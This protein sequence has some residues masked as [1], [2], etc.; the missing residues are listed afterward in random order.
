[1]D[2][3]IILGKAAYNKNQIAPKIG[4]GADG[5]EIQLLNEMLVLNGKDRCWKSMSE[6][7]DCY[8]EELTKHIHAIHAPLLKG[9]GDMTLEN[10]MDI[11]DCSVLS[12][13]AHVANEIGKKF[14]RVITLIVHSEQLVTTMKDV[15]GIY[16][17]IVRSL[18][19]LLNNYGY[20]RVGIE[21][22]SPIR[23]LSVDNL[24]LSNNFDYNNVVLANMLRNELK[25]N[26]VGTILDT[27]HAMI[28]EKY[29]QGI[30]K[31]IDD[32]D[33]LVPELSMAR[34]FLENG[35]TIFHIHLCDM[36]GCGYGK[37]RHGIPFTEA[38]KDKLFS[39]LDLYTKYRY[40][41][42]LCLEVEEL[43]GFDECTG[44]RSTKALVDE[45]FRLWDEL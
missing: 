29:I 10:M 18:D 27:C 20:V 7:Y 21:N 32:S 14:N 22:V 1:M 39:I 19:S 33:Y 8:N 31:I 41:C 13:M 26:R 43:D 25:T 42:P 35:D 17:K 4:F 38:T 15:G 34:F 28:T 11:E 9:L 24:S 12:E 40:D 37:G 2:K 45:Y 5:I 30:Y 6:V 3:P 36:A 16:S 44:F 23:E